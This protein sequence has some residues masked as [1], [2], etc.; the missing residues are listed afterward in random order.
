MANSSLTGCASP[1]SP[2]EINNTDVNINRTEAKRTT[3]GIVFRMDF[4]IMMNF[5]ITCKSNVII[6]IYDLLFSIYYLL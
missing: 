4:F 2:A 5:F 6:L 1:G 3:D